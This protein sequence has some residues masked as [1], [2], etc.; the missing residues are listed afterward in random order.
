MLEMALVTDPVSL[1]LS[2]SLSMWF[3]LAS[4]FFLRSLVLLEKRG[5]GGLSCLLDH[6]IRLCL[7]ITVVVGGGGLGMFLILFLSFVSGRIGLFHAFRLGVK[8]LTVI[9]VYEC[10][11]V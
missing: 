10:F 4:T 8:R 2:S 9:F 1:R 6:G 3:I 7:L 11:S 5:N